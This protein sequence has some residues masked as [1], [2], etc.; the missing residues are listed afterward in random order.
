[1]HYCACRVGAAACM[2]TNK[3]MHV[4][5]QRFFLFMLTV[6]P[7]RRRTIPVSGPADGLWQ[8]VC[9]CGSSKVRKDLTT[10]TD[11][12]PPAAGGCLVASN[13]RTN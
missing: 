7:G 10:M 9:T 5:G 11:M 12:S 1:V 8:C 2:Q 6:D 4:N 13:V 3:Q